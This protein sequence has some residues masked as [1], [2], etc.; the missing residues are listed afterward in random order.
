MQ[1]TVPA[2]YQPLV[3]VWME[4]ATQLSSPEANLTLTTV[5]TSLARLHPADAVHR[6]GMPRIHSS[7]GHHTTH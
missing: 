3:F 4:G 6:C 5:N 2:E 7:V 1:R